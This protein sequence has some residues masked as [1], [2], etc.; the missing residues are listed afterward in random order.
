LIL[1]DGRIL[2]QQLFSTFLDDTLV[3]LKLKKDHFNIH[4]FRI[5]VVTSEKE[6]GMPDVFIK[7]MGQWCS[8]SYQHIRKLSSLKKIFFLIPRS[9]GQ[10]QEK[11]F[12]ALLCSIK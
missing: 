11:V 3:A 8:D 1:N 6:A 4:S 2:T 10:H 9:I 5:G 7:I 12:V